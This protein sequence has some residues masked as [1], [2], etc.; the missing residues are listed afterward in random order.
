M[1]TNAQLVNEENISIIKKA[2]S[3]VTV[4]IDSYNEEYNDSMRGKGTFRY[5]KRAIS[6]FLANEIT[7]S[8]NVVI[9]NR[10][11]GDYKQTYDMLV[12]LG[13]QNISPMPVNVLHDADSGINNMRPTATQVE[14]YFDEI[15]SSDVELSSRIDRIFSIWHGC[16][17]A[18]RE[19]AVDSCGNLYPCR[20]MMESGWNAGE[21]K[22]DNFQSVWEHSRIL[23][24]IRN[25]HSESIVCADCVY[26]RHCRGGCLAVNSIPGKLSTGNSDYACHWIR[27]N[28]TKV[29]AYRTRLNYRKKRK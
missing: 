28:Y 14:S 24:D 25:F 7:W 4:S 23:N 17:A 11:I 3:R 9:T 21:L 1:I 13:A 29:F 12:K 20:L 15:F 5:I 27:K 8:A 6:L 16:G 19:F 10:N 2:F 22:G 26:F 18:S